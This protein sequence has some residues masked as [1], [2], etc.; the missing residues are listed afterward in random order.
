[1]K[2][3]TAIICTLALLTAFT[4]CN[5]SETSGSV[6]ESGNSV[7]SPENMVSDLESSDSS[8]NS[9]STPESSESVSEST[10]SQIDHSDLS[11]QAREILSRCTLD[12]SQ[13]EGQNGAPLLEEEIVDAYVDERIEA[14][15]I[16]YGV[17]YYRIARPLYDVAEGGDFTEMSDHIY[18][19]TDEFEA[20]TG[21]VSLKKVKVGD[22]LENGLTVKEA[23]T[24]IF[25]DGGF[26]ASYI[27]LGGELTAEGILFREVQDHDYRFS[28]R[29]LTF[30]PNC[31]KSKIPIGINGIDFTTLP[32]TNGTFTAIVT[33][34]HSF[35]LGNLDEID[36]D[37]Q[38][39]F[40]EENFVQ[41]RVTM[42]N[43]SFGDK[44][45]PY[46]CEAE[47]VDIERI[48]E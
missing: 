36:F 24:V 23:K 26:G 28:A 18:E 25:S 10:T 42:D 3:F 37:E 22:T 20:D 5:N 13:V 2:K 47:I 27:T 11:E 29:D 46:F 40:G 4:G 8:D 43:I 39:I 33:D 21:E 15:C 44:Y 16:E 1:M 12:L 41:V 7:S 32:D 14:E 31:E 30:F 45:G 6:P 34:G 17:G 48:D 9:E 38:G 19:K 35:F